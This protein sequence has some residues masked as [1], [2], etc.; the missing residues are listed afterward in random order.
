MVQ[1]LEQIAALMKDVGNAGRRC[2]RF[3]ASLQIGDPH[4][5]QFLPRIAGFTDIG[6]V[7]FQQASLQIQHPE[8]VQRGIDGGSI[9]GFPVTQHLIGFNLFRHVLAKGQEAFRR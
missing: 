5:Q 7:Y 8:T 3:F 6:V 1:G 4:F 9:A 2:R